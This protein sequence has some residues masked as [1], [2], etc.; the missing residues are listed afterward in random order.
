MSQLQELEVVVVLVYWKQKYISGVS[1]AVFFF[2]FLVSCCWKGNCVLRL[3]CCLGLWKHFS[4]NLEKIFVCEKKQKKNR[5]INLTSRHYKYL[6]VKKKKK[7]FS[8]YTLLRFSLL[9]KFWPILSLKCKRDRHW[10]QEGKKSTNVMIQTI[11]ILS[12]ICIDTQN[13]QKKKGG[14]NGKWAVGASLWNIAS[15]KIRDVKY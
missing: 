9:P 11:F 3:T 15:A 6:R 5:P 10:K 12:D 8:T 4:V 14:D 2:F 1:F 13:W 7:Y